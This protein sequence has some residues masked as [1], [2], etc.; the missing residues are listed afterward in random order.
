[1]T[2]YF[3]TAILAALC[4]FSK[5]PLEGYSEPETCSYLYIDSSPYG[6]TSDGLLIH[7]GSNVWVN[8]NKA[9]EHVRYWK[10]PYCYKHWPEGVTCQNPNCPS[11]YR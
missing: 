1:M 5:S 10:C 6:I 11:K 3:T 7:I 8:S 2:Y 4:L 9:T